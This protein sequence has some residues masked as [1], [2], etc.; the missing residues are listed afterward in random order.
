M[1]SVIVN[2]DGFSRLFTVNE[3]ILAAYPE[4]Q[5]SANFIVIQAPEYSWHLIDQ[6]DP[7]DIEKLTKIINQAYEFINDKDDDFATKVHDLIRLEFK[8]D[9]H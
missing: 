3:H 2:R 1:F 9:T 4:Y 5:P 6:P 8:K 7:S